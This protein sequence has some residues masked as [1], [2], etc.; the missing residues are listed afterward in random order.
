MCEKTGMFT[1]YRRQN[2]GKDS[3]IQTEEAIIDLFL[4]PG[5]VD[6]GIIQLQESKSTFGI[7]QTFIFA[8]QRT[9]MKMWEILKHNQTNEIQLTKYE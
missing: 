1:V 5:D 9:Q 3:T 4:E 2:W 6:V 8:T 7:F